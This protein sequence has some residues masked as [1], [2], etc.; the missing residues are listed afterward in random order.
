[1]AVMVIQVMLGD[2]CNAGIVHVGNDGNA[3]NAGIKVV[4]YS[5][6][7]NG[8]IFKCKW[9]QLWYNYTVRYSW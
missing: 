2:I 8:G 7:N 9:W 4:I 6:P 5:N 3:G 1:M